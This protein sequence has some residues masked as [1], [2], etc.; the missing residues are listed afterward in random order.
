MLA[1]ELYAN[2]LLSRDETLARLCEHAQGGSVAVFPTRENP[3]V[4]DYNLKKTYGRL[5]EK[6]EQAFAK[7][8]PLFSLA[9]YFPLGYYIGPNNDYHGFVLN[10]GQYTTIDEPNAAPGP[11]LGTETI[12][13]N[14][15]GQI[16]NDE[17]DIAPPKS[18]I[19]TF[20]KF[21]IILWHF[22]SLRMMIR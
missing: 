17:G 5:L 16:V 10:Q 6:V 13:I 19:Q 15:A 1:T 21:G 14:A 2:P 12:D 9:I 22:H 8:K 4:A 11:G 3:R 18:F 7:D 20:Y